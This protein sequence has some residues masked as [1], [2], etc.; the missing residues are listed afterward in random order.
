MDDRSREEEF[1][2]QL[3]AT[4]LALNGALKHLST[5]QIRFLHDVESG[6][7]TDLTA[8]WSSRG[9]LSVFEKHVLNEKKRI[10]FRLGNQ[11][12]L[13]ETGEWG[14]RSDA[15]DLHLFCIQCDMPTPFLGLNSPMSCPKCG[16]SEF[17]ETLY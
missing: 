7:L 16:S 15:T 13:M 14:N 9:P 2:G 4:R 11:L 6:T 1:R 8:L 3:M 5:E 17:L 12:N 10:V